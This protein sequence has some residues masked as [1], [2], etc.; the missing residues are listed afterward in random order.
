MRLTPED[1]KKIQDLSLCISMD[2]SR[3][4]G[5]PPTAEFT[6]VSMLMSI[7]SN[8]AQLS[9]LINKLMDE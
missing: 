1:L 8:G 5:I 6:L 3:L 7:R 4:A 2:T 9:L